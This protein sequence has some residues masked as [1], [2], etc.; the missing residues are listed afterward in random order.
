MSQLSTEQAFTRRRLCMRMSARC[1]DSQWQCGSWSHHAKIQV[2]TASTKP[3]KDSGNLTA[4]G[5]TN[6]HFAEPPEDEFPEGDDV[7]GG[8]RVPGLLRD[9]DDGVSGDDG[10]GRACRGCSG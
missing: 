10:W 6:E 3:G 5:G 7:S 2:E 1:S 4:S 9:D 8:R